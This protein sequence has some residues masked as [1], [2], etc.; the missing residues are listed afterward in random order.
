MHVPGILMEPPP[1]VSLPL[2]SSALRRARRATRGFFLLTGIAA[3]SWAPMVPFAKAR[4]QVDEAHLGVLLL[5]M[6]LGAAGSMPLAGHLSHRHGSR[7]VLLI[8]GLVVAAMLPL[9]AIASSMAVL[10]GALVVFGGALGVVDV[11][12]NAHAVDVETLHG[13]PLMSG[14]HGLYSIGGLVGAAGMSALLDGGM[15]LVACTLSVAAVLVAIVASQGGALLVRPPDTKP[16]PRSMFAVPSATAVLLGLLCLGIFLI[17][18]AMLDWS[19]VFLRSA[20]GFAISNAGLGFAAFSV[21][22]AAG[23][24]LGDRITA[25]L[26]PVRVVRYGS[27]TAVAGL[28]AACALPWATTSLVGFVLVGLGASNIVPVL[29]S[30]AG[31]IPDTSPGVAIATVTALGYSGMLAGPAVIGVVARATSLPLAL[32]GTALLLAAVAASAAIVRRGEVRP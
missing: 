19:A 23:R 24:L 9:L 17:E 18:G 14:F 11:A 1:P 22:M 15:P 10:G 27:V 16:A 25:A 2:S 13:R 20:R 5:C 3:G 28:V 32:G 6:G 26:G 31:R 7:N 12:V 8:G 29:F 30:A 21:A 4:L